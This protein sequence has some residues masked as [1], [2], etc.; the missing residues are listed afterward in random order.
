VTIPQ[1][2]Q[3]LV[4]WLSARPGHPLLT[5]LRANDP[6]WIEHAPPPEGAVGRSAY[7]YY[8][9]LLE[10]RRR[11]PEIART[12][13]A[14]SRGREPVDEDELNTMRPS[15]ISPSSMSFRPAEK[16]WSSREM[17]DVFEQF[18]KLIWLIDTHYRG[19]LLAPRYLANFAAFRPTPFRAE[20]TQDVRWPFEI[21]GSTMIDL[22]GDSGL[23]WL[24]PKSSGFVAISC[25]LIGRTRSSWA[26][27]GGE[28]GLKAVLDAKDTTGGLSTSIL[29]GRNVHPCMAYQDCAFRL[30]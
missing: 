11:L 1:V 23:T 22:P 25:A 20:M 15:S 7:D 5:A 29:G 12:N 16:Q 6:A 28:R 19:C 17:P 10:V 30:A 21:A 2:N 3:E 8:V 13:F 4:Q 24:L 27:F 9:S 18:Y 14:M 26:G